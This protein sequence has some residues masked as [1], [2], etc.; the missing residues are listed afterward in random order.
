M[1]RQGKARCHPT[2]AVSSGTDTRMR[3]DQGSMGT[4]PSAVHIVK[5][6]RARATSSAL[7]TCVCVPMMGDHPHE[8]ECCGQN[9]PRPA[10]AIKTHA[11][12]AAAGTDTHRAV[13]SS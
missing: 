12:D 11:T 10:P 1:C 2:W 4:T 13:A 6:E 7:S 3:A 5:A 9:D 8:V